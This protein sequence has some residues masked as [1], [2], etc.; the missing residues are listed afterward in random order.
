MMNLYPE[1]YRQFA[2][3][4]EQLIREMEKQHNNINLTDE[5][6][7]E[8]IDEVIRRVDAE[9]EAVPVIPVMADT[10]DLGNMEMGGDTLDIPQGDAI[11]VM[12]RMG[13]GTAARGHGHHG[14]HHGHRHGHRHHGCRHGNCGHVSD[15]LRILFLQQI[16][17]RR[18]PHWRR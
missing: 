2:P 11:Q 12:Y 18:R 3:F 14:S 4:T 8:M 17:G 9:S 15:I 16:F 1:I 7:A 5:L 10:A 6:L 13:G